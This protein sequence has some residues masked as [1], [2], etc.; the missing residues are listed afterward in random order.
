MRGGICGFGA[1]SESGQRWRPLEGGEEGVGI[2]EAEFEAALAAIGE[3]KVEQDR[4]SEKGTGKLRGND[5]TAGDAMLE[6][7]A[8]REKVEREN[9]A[10]PN[11]GIGDSNAKA[12]LRAAE[13]RPPSL[14]GA[15]G[16]I[17]FVEEW[18]DGFQRWED[19]AALAMAAD[20]PGQIREHPEE[21]DEKQGSE[22]LADEGFERRHAE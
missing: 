3:A 6:I 21:P 7:V 9:E 2:A 17:V 22:V 19:E 1:R 11:L 16:S 10:K 13:S 15:A 14:V 18:M 5:G 4:P 20:A 8:I 12:I